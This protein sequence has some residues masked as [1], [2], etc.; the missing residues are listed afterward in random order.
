MRYRISNF[1]FPVSASVFGGIKK[2]QFHRER[3]HVHA[4][5][6]VARMMRFVYQIFQ[7]AP[8]VQS[9]SFPTGFVP[10]VAPIG[11]KYSTKKKI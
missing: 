4:R 10:S 11:E 6:T 3:L 7:H 1:E 2:W 5:V 8:N 9:P